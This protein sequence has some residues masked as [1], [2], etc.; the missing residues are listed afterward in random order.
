MKI[1]TWIDNNLPKDLS[2]KSFLITGSNSGIGYE[3][4]KIVASL[5]GRLYLAVRNLSKGEEAKKEL[6]KI[7]PN[8]KIDV[9]ELNL[10]DFASI[11]KFSHYIITNKIDIDY[12]YNNAGV[13]R[14]PYSLTK[15]CIETQLGTNYIGTLLLMDNLVDYLLSL[16][17]KVKITF[18]NSVVTYYYKYNI[19]HFFPTEKDKP[20]KTYANTKTMTTH[21]FYYFYKKYEGTNLSFYLAHPGSTFTPLIAKGYQNQSIR[22]L[23]RRFMKTFFH[24]PPKACLVYASVIKDIPNGSYIV[25]RGL[26]E[27]TGFPKLKKIKEKQIK[28]YEKTVDIGEET[29]SIHR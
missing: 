20:I 10:A 29:I 16:P 14:L 15:Q 5:N 28:D 23:G 24:L 1:K 3:L 12:F 11:D 8:A 19:D 4:A 17:H 26:L 13:Y 6:L 9:L 21:M 22:Y 7:N 2:G 27:M 25:P 18:V